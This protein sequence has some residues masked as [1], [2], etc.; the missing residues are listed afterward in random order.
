MSP[1]LAKQVEVLNPSL[2]SVLFHPQIIFMALFCTGSVFIIP[3][4]RVDGLS[5]SSPGAGVTS[6]PLGLSSL[7]TSRSRIGFLTAESPW[8]LTP[9]SRSVLALWDQLLRAVPAL[10][11]HAARTPESTTGT[12]KTCVRWKLDLA[13]AQHPE[14]QLLWVC[15]VCCYPSALQSSC[16][17]APKAVTAILSVTLR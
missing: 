11:D 9:K 10:P 12:G 13:C 1:Q 16:P 14:E 3:L 2:Q 17:A 4:M 15:P 8:A 5:P 6:L 7:G